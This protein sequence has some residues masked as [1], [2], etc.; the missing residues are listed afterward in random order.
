MTW[1]CFISKAISL[2]TLLSKHKFLPQCKSSS[3][4]STLPFCSSGSCWIFH[5]SCH[6]DIRIE[7]DVLLPPQYCFQTLFLQL[8]FKVLLLQDLCLLARPSSPISYHCIQNSP[9]VI[10]QGK[11][12]W[13]ASL[14]FISNLAVTIL[15]CPCRWAIQHTGLS[16]SW[17]TMYSFYTRL[18]PACTITHQ[19][20]H[21]EIFHFP[22][23]S[24]F[25]TRT[26]S[27]LI[28]LFFLLLFFEVIGTSNS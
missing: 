11:H 27:L 10:Q 26:S 28:Y 1:I 17:H 22:I 15:L 16:F 6:S 8:F 3:A 9:P 19:D 25:F 12:T 20:C 5:N 4:V 24:S 2:N 13:T 14:L 18:Q 7:I 23:P 21:S